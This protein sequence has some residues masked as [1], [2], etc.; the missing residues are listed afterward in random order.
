VTKGTLKKA[1][2]KKKGKL[3]FTVPVTFTPRFG[4]AAS[5]DTPSLTFKAKKKKGNEKKG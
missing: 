4:T 5:L 1:R 2:K 3:R